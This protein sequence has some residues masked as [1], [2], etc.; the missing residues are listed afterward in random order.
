MNVQEFIIKKKREK[1]SNTFSFGVT[2]Y[3]VSMPFLWIL[4]ILLYSFFKKN[5][6]YGVLIVA[7]ILVIIFF[8]VYPWHL[9]EYISS[10]EKGDFTYSIGICNYVSNVDGYP[11]IKDESGE[12]IKQ[13]DIVLIAEVNGSESYY[14]I[15]NIDLEE[16]TNQMRS[17]SI[18]QEK[19]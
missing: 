4:Y 12:I 17:L 9:D 1:C 13:G 10:V 15:T 6:I 14:N 7:I 18:T 5:A 8:K 11:Y 3:F 16:K 19:V 2:V